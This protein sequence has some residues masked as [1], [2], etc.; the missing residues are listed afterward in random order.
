LIQL[1][2][3]FHSEPELGL[4]E[5]KTAEFIADYLK[6]LG[7]EVR[8][9]VAKTGVV[10]TLKGELPGNVV[11]LRADIDALPI[12]E[13]GEFEYKSKVDGKMHACAHD[14]HTAIL[15][16][17]AKIL[18]ENKD[19]LPGAVKFVFQ[20]NEE[21]VAGAKVMIDEGALR[22]PDVDVMLGL[23]IL[24]DIDSGYIEVKS[25]TIMA[26]RDGF[27]ITIIGKG[28]HGASPHLTVDPVM[29]GAQIVTAIQ[30]IVSRK[31][32]PIQAAVV[33]VC[34]F[35]A[36]G[37]R[38]NIIPPTAYLAGTIRSMDES[39]RQMIFNQLSTIAN[40]ICESAGATCE[41]KIK[42]EIP[43]V[44]NDPKLFEEFVR[45]S[46][47]VL[48]REALKIPGQG[49]MY[50][51]DFS[52]FGE[53]VPAVYFF[54]GTRNEAKGCVHPVHSPIFKLDEDVLPLGTALLVNYCL[55]RE[56]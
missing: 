39:V 31:I 18:A 7:M 41:V 50:S 4:E 11:G 43:A 22:D 13:E 6:K 49:R 36:G 29:I 21:N 10:A 14:G 30:T 16:G 3:R 25:G 2:R 34:I 45:Y 52:L 46:Y 19:R 48:D 33:S 37:E 26:S 53:C 12:T 17:A 23:H 32:S 42:E 9:G 1:R 54:L 44:N 38:A 55:S 20:P 47:D 24:P 15:L 5:Y 40:G 28:G 51:E 8:T 35:Q 27:E 56:A